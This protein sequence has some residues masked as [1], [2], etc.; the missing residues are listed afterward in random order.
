MPSRSRGRDRHDWLVLVGEEEQRRIEVVP[1]EQLV[2]ALGILVALKPRPKLASGHSRLELG[3]ALVG[4]GDGGL[5]H[6]VLQA[7]PGRPGRAGG[8]TGPRW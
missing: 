3:L 6:Q 2:L 8:R 7:D 4:D 5:L 1:R